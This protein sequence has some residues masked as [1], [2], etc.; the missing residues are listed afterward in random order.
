MYACLCVCVS[1]CLYLCMSMCLCVYVSACLCDCMFA[2]LCVCISVCL[3][4]YVSACLCVCM[5]VCLCVCVCVSVCLCVCVYVS[6]Y[7]R[8]CVSVCLFEQIN[9]LIR[10]RRNCFDFGESDL[11]LWTWQL[12]QYFWQ[13]YIAT[14]QTLTLHAANAVR[15]VRA[16]PY[17][18]ERGCRVDPRHTYQ[19]PCEFTSM[20]VRSFMLAQDTDCSVLHIFIE[21][22]DSLSA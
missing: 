8:V 22:G 15:A 7:L 6:V 13:R 12:F 4:V 19:T 20:A 9:L 3:C 10:N 11:D 14:R 16:S 17:L 18:P 1:V 2:C 5:S 21:T